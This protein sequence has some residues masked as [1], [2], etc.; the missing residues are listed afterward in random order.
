MSV[1]VYSYHNKIF[2]MQLNLKMLKICCLIYFLIPD[3]VIV[4][5]F[6][7]IIPDG[8]IVLVFVGVFFPPNNSI[9]AFHCY[10]YRGTSI[11]YI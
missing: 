2:N 5:V 3:G 6:L 9:V 4:L 7:N 11:I 8:V 1:T 10:Y